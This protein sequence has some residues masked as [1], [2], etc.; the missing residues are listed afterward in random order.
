MSVVEDKAKGIIELENKIPE[1]EARVE[2]C[3]EEFTSLQERK[4]TGAEVDPKAIKA[5]KEAWESAKD[6]VQFAKRTLEKL[7]Q[8][9]ITCI[10]EEKE[11][12]EKLLDGINQERIRTSEKYAADLFK[13]LVQLCAKAELIFGS[14]D[15]GWFSSFPIIGCRFNLSDFIQ[16]VSSQKSTIRIPSPTVLE[17]E[18]RMDQINA[19]AK[20]LPEEQAKELLRLARAKNSN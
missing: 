6:D 1:Y 11:K 4:I 15:Y 17:L 12:R 19:L 20:Q 13:D 10:I 18:I 8:R 5:A 2:K 3:E 14:S 9:F 7:N 16:E